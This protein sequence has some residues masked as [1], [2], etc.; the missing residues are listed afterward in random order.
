MALALPPKSSCTPSD[1]PTVDRLLDS[2]IATRPGAITTYQFYEEVDSWLG[3]WGAGGYPIG[4]G[5]KYNIAF[6]TNPPLNRDLM[7][8]RPWVQKTTV[9]LQEALKGFLVR[10]VSSGAVATMDEPTLR[11]AA[12]DT[13]PK[14]YLDAG[15]LKVA[16]N[17]PELIA[18]I[19]TIPIAEFSPTSPNFVATWIQVFRVLSMPKIVDLLRAVL[20]AEARSAPPAIVIRFI[21][22]A[23]ASRIP[24]LPAL[25]PGARDDNFW[26][27]LGGW[28][29]WVNIFD[30]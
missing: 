8:G 28:G 30:R 9:L 12:F 5:K 2:V 15:L 6:A 25:P 14:A 17:S 1:A 24:G 26:D 22:E 10:Q 11:A 4:Y 18:V 23:A 21:W 20:G 19:M 7:Y 13:H 16:E 29:G 3:P 27:K